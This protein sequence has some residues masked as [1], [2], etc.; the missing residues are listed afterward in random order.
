[1]KLEKKTGRTKVYREKAADLLNP[2]SLETE[3]LLKLM[4][5]P[6]LSDYLHFHTSRVVGGEEMARSA[7]VDEWRTANDH[8][9]DLEASELGEAESIESFDLLKSLKA[10][11]IALEENRFFQESFGELPHAI[12]MVE[13]RKL[14]V[15]QHSVGTLF[16]GSIADRLG[17][18]PTDKDLFAFC[19]PTGKSSAPLTMQR[20]SESRYVFTSRST[21]FRDHPL[22]VAHAGDLGFIDSFGPV[23]NA[24]VIP[25]GYGSNF[26]S[27]I[28]SEKR[29]V[30]QNGYHR[31]FALMSLGI[32][33]APMVIQH[34]SRTDELDLAASSEV[35]DNAIFY[36][37][38]K[39]PPLLKDFLN[40]K[41]AKRIDIHAL[42]TR[43]EIEVKVR[44]STGPVAK[45]L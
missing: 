21:D 29:I 41:L 10:Q 39:R 1:M 43:V 45:T 32:T 18:A 16:A 15:S 36:F 25:L 40:A 22:T 13:L 4:G 20:L 44:N 35:S 28:E 11:A 12:K 23:A 26:L 34:V 9:H 27:G 14:M 24:L 19:L 3:S 38:A 2:A 8:Y 31:A 42:E 5:L 6:G 7:L 30:L 33:H 17:K 37:R